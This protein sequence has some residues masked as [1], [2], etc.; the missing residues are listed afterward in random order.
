MGKG[1]RLGLPAAGRCILPPFRRSASKREAQRFVWKKGQ[2][3]AHDQSTMAF[4]S[5]FV[6]TFCFCARQRQQREQWKEKRH[7]ETVKTAAIKQSR[8]ADYN[9][10]FEVNL[11]GRNKRGE[12]IR[13]GEHV[14]QPNRVRQIDRK[15]STQFAEI[16]LLQ[17][18]IK[19]VI[20]Q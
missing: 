6:R 8:Q 10:E 7:K 9:R 12:A 15:A 13:H 18:Y 1:W 19:R 16:G 4:F 11:V 3:V 5:C 14:S 2:A 20:I 17:G